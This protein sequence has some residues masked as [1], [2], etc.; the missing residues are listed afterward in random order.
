MSKINVE[1][2]KARLANEFG[3]SIQEAETIAQDIMV[4]NNPVHDAF[5]H[6]WQTREI[7][8]LTVQ[9]Y[10]IES[11][12]EKYGMNTIA[13]FLTLG[14]LLDDPKAALNSIAQGYDQIE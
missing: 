8:P 2:I 3:Y 7:R 12:Q 9:K 11:L 4:L 6:W 10:S 13:A 14:W 5:I 1:E